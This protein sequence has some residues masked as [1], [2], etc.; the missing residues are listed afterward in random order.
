LRVELFVLAHSQA[1]ERMIV[2]VRRE[3][4]SLKIGWLLANGLKVLFRAI[5]YRREI[6]VILTGERFGGEND[7]ML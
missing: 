6:F 2:A 1:I 7:L 3:F 4:L 5:Q